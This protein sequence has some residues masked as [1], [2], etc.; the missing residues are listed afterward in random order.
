ML[1]VS[2][3]R[4]IPHWQPE[5]CLAGINRLFGLDGFVAQ[6]FCEFV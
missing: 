6:P 4:G 5:N 3:D 2:G 1:K